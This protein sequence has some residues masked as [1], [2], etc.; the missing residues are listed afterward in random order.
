MRNRGSNR[1]SVRAGADFMS[2]AM[3]SEISRRGLLIRGVGI[4]GLVAI[5]GV[6]AA[7]GS[8]GSSP[9]NADVATADGNV[10][11]EIDY[12]SWEGYDLPKVMKN[13]EQAHGVTLNTTYISNNDETPA[14]VKSGS[15]S[16]DLITYTHFF[17]QSWSDLGIISDLD[18]DKLPNLEG[19]FPVFKSDIGNYWLESGGTWTGVPWSFGT[20]GLTWDEEALPGGLNSYFDLL[21]PK[22]KGKVGIPDDPIGVWQ[23]ACVAFGY[24]PGKITED[25][26]AD[27]TDF[28]RKIVAQAKTVSPTFGDVATLFGSREIMVAFDGWAALNV[29]SAD[30]GNKNVTSGLPEEGG[31]SFADVYAIPT[32]ADNVD[33]VLAWINHVLTPEVNA[34]AAENLVAG[35]TIEK[36]VPLLNE[37]T[38]ALYPYDDLEAYLSGA[39]FYDNP[40]MESDEYVTYPEMLTQWKSIQ[41]GS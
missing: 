32:S 21:D 3:D 6:L 10:G 5:P 38:K 13:W 30:A 12:L 37:S 17:K 34:Q 28:L 41:A 31:Y 2:P 40:P 14:K 9:K 15:G 24:D 18:A 1:S 20:I 8:D 35:V 36:A 39:T 11:G 27:V 4:A 25:Q 26:N 16:Y 33:T 23:T 7:C 19:E 22:F 29:F